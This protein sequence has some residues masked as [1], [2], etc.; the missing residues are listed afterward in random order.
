MSR[1]RFFIALVVGAAAILVVVLLATGA[2]SGAGKAGVASTPSPACL[3]ST[4]NHDARLAGTPFEVSP[5]P[6]TG[7][8]N[9]DTQ[10]SFLGAPASRISGV[11][12]VGSDSG[13]HHGSLRAYSQGDGASF[14]AEEP[15][16]PGER[17][18]VRATILIGHSSA[19]AH[20]QKQI[21][22]GFRIDTPYSTA[23]VPP[24]PNPQAAPADY[25]SFDTLP[26][27]Q[28]PILSVTVADRDKGAGDVFTTN[29]PGP[30]QYGALIYSPQGRL[31]WFDR[32]PNG[33]TA[34]NLSV[35]SYEGRPALTFW[36]GKVLSLGFGQGEDVVLGSNYRTLAKVP[37]GNGLQA[38]L[39]DFRVTPEEVSY[40]TAFNPIRCD[41][42]SVEGSHD[43]V[44]LD[45]A[46]QEIDM[47]TG[48]VRWEWHSL[49]HVAASESE[50]TTPTKPTPWDWFHINSIDLEPG[51]DVFISARSTWAGYQIEGG[52]GNVLWR[53]GGLKS[54]F[55][56]GPGTETAWQHDGRVLPDGLVTFFDDGSNPPIH[57]QSRGLR[58]A[59][60][61]MTHKARLVSAYTHPDPPLLAPSQG[62]MQT[63]PDGNAVVGYGGVPAISEFATDG[64]L[65]FDAHLP[66]DL[67]FYRAFRFPWSGHP[68]SP[69]AA[70]ANLNDTSE[71]TIVHV[72][73][74]GA[75]E[76]TSWRVLAGQHPNS[77]R[78][79]TVI[80]AS[81][82]ESSTTL[83]KKYAY[84]A[85]Q[86]LDSAGRALGSSKPVA[87]TS[88]AAALPSAG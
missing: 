67:S 8:A 84:A 15:F 42:S 11:S 32:V 69:P 38:D 37:G 51:G 74:N 61:F 22:F 78:A 71:G 43:G 58:I 81:D 54:S 79:Q 18:S 1:A 31:V 7:T 25:Q 3:P 87:V 12:V 44:I 52:S 82:F 59:L 66:Y 53:L 19:S 36:K 80:P 33:E 28:V 56:M 21:A 34:E 45:T 9:P 39:H 77:L 47:K 16:D 70:L 6:E 4:L 88:Y 63:L 73:W 75:T 76:V 48:L 65:L 55:K 20:E 26:G 60:D 10:I 57:S 14:V 72:S 64:S 29:G 68:S 24:F 46:I 27:L 49:D 62:N 17:V 41:L 5:A 86:A 2:L 50:T 40:T 30:G 13:A 35:Q 23:N 85:V 83:P